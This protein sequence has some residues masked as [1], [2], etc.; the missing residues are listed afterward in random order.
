MEHV[1]A[2]GPA[3]GLD[4]ADMAAA[5]LARLADA[6]AVSDHLDLLDDDLGIRGHVLEFLARDQP[7]LEAQVVR[8]E[9]GID[10]EIK[11][12]LRQLVWS[13]FVLLSSTSATT[14]LTRSTLGEIRA[15]PVMSWVAEACVAETLAVGRALG[16]ALGAD[17]EAG[18]LERL[19]CGMSADAKASQ[20]VDLERGKP[21][22]LEYLSGAVHRLGREV[23]VPTPVHTTVYAALKRYLHGR[24]AGS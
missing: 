4:D 24:P 21:L 3:V 20:L 7:L 1:H 19:R 18:A 9:A 15:D 11:T 10:I 12:D 2:H 5:Q 13:K 22:E 6:A 8:A 14:A 16:V 23:G 17:I